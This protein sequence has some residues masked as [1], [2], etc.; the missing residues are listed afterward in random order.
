MK[1]WTKF[2]HFHSRKCIWKCV[3]DDITR[4]NERDGVPNAQPLDCLPNRVFRHISENTS[5]LRVAGLCEGNSPVT[6]WFP[7]Q[8]ASNAENVSI[9]WRYHGR[10]F[11]PGLNVL[12]STIFHCWDVCFHR[13]VA[14]CM[15]CRRFEKFDRRL[16]PD[17]IYPNSRVSCPKGPIFHAEAWRVGPFWQDTIELKADLLRI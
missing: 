6:G 7:A 2:I 12:I 5:K 3:R 4:H 17:Y 11:C 13:E 8:M 9:W 10:Q 15:D 1:T 14:Q 16:S